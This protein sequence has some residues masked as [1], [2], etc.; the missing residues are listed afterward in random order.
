MQAWETQ[1]TK[2]SLLK[3]KAQ[4][5][6]KSMV[7]LVQLKSFFRQKAFQFGMVSN[8]LLNCL[9]ESPLDQKPE[10]PEI[11]SSS[12]IRAV[13]KKVATMTLWSPDVYFCWPP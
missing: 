11:L 3:M 9:L 13:Y 10:V 8:V 5:P 12:D 4:R 2:I 1:T 6:Y 7:L